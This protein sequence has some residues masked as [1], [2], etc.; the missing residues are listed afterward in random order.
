[1]LEEIIISD[2]TNALID[3]RET[4]NKLDRLSVYVTRVEHRLKQLSKQLTLVRDHSD[5][6]GLVKKGLKMLDLKPRHE[7]VV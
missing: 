6:K 3:R 5:D 2:D 7:D 1:M 4:Q